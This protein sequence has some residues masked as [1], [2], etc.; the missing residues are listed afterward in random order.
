MP[1]HV[2]VSNGG[3][4]HLSRFILDQNTGALAA[5]GDVELG[6]A[7]GSLSASA[8]RCRKAS[9]LVTR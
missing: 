6:G 2:Y 9:C 4:T 7:P 3:S 1:C 8:E 5:Q